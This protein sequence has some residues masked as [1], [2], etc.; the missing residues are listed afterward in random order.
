MNLSVNKSKN[1]R[2][3]IALF[4]GAH[5]FVLPSLVNAADKD[6]ALLSGMPSYE[7]DVNEVVEYGTYP[8]QREFMC[9]P[10]RRC[11]ASDPGFNAEGKLVAEGKVTILRYANKG[12][13]Q[14]LAVT[15]NYEAAIKAAGGRKLTWQEGHEGEQV[16]LVDKSGRRTWVVLDNNYASSYK[17]TYVEAKPMEQVVTAG[18]LADAIKKQGFATIHINFANNSA[19]LPADGRKTVDE[20]AS[21]LAADKG[22]RLSI[23]GHTDNVGSAS[24]NKTLSQA[25]ADSVVKSL[26][27]AKVDAKRL[28]AKGF[29]SEVPVADNRTEEGRGQNRRVE[30]VRLK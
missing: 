19:T 13:G 22:L 2:L 16:F 29:G 21:L 10:N 5:F 23:Q 20:I 28:E 15:R 12:N 25:R 24:S 26:V 11:N 14:T 4:L 18:E 17:L 9:G 6:H 3:A 1:N 7:V 27:Q 30:L 8:G